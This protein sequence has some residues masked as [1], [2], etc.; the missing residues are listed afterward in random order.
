[1]ASEG[2]QNGGR[3]ELMEEMKKLGIEFTA[4]VEHPE[5]SLK[6]S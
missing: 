4:S 3:S 1:M 5:V 2:K 6:H